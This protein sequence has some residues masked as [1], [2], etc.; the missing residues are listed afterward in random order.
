MTPRG[1]AWLDSRAAA[2]EKQCRP[3]RRC[4]IALCCLIWIKAAME[5]SSYPEPE[6][7]DALPVTSRAA[8]G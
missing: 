8:R 3:P 1:S 7:D 4:N 2:G 6:N 5:G